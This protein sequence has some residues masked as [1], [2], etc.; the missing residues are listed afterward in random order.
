MRDP[1][2]SNGFL[3][4]IH[5]R[6]PHS[7]GSGSQRNMLSKGGCINL[8]YKMD[9]GERSRII[10]KVCKRHLWESPPYSSFKSEPNPFHLANSF[11]CWHRMTCCC[12]WAQK[13]DSVVSPPSI[14]GR[15]N[16]P[17]PFH[18]S[19]RE[20]NL[21]DVRT[22]GATEWAMAQSYLIRSSDRFL[23]QSYLKDCRN[24]EGN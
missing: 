9:I 13:M 23:V 21:T 12:C 1:P 4:G 19:R 17:I 7:M 8:L 14:A 24:T 5:I 18:Q 11:L 16:S 22:D 15:R 3:G 2:P 20:I 10:L 6:S